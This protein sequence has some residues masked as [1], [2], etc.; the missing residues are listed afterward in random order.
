MHDQRPDQQVVTDV[1]LDN[2]KARERSREK[3]SFFRSLNLCKMNITNSTLYA[4]MMQ[5]DVSV[6]LCELK[7]T[8][9]GH[10]L[11]WQPRVPA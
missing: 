2:C 7:D 3:K 10:S 9:Y 11:S 5:T 8:I 1:T 4:E 6:E